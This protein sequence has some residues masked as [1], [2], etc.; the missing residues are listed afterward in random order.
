[1][2]RTLGFVFLLALLC[3]GAALAPSPMHA[4]AIRVATVKP[5]RPVAPKALTP[6]KGVAVHVV[7][8]KR[9][10]VV[11]RW[12]LGKNG[13]RMATY[14]VTAIPDS[15]SGPLD[16]PDGDYLDTVSNYILTDGSFSTSGPPPDTDVTLTYPETVGVTV[17]NGIWTA[18]ES[19]IA[20]TIDDPSGHLAVGDHVLINVSYALGF[21]I[22][23]IYV[24]SGTLPAP[25]PTP[26][27]ASISASPNPA[28]GVDGA[29][30]VSW[31]TSNADTAVVS[32]PG[33]SSTALSGSVPVTLAASP[34]HYTI[35]ATNASG[36][37]NAS[38]DATV[39]DPTCSIYADP[40]P[41][42]V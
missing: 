41:V 27:T 19:S 29:T 42:T 10:H 37:A 23:I 16:I 18:D 9:G 39:S 40:N 21:P 34:S 31:S 26:P 30:T 13:K 12:W 5:T 2:K 38:T 28:S 14:Y 20:I 6:P 8:D 22:E 15:P 36:T 24:F 4:R 11:E 7:N 33:V 35:A 17:S 32:G 25:P 1:M 3:A